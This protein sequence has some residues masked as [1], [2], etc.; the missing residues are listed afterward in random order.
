MADITLETLIEDMAIAGGPDFR[1]YKRN[2]LERSLRKRM[3]DL[4]L[5]SL[6][7]YADFFV[8]NRSEVNHLQQ[9]LLINVTAFFRDSLAWEALAR[10]ALP[11]LLDPL[12]PGDTFHAWCAGCATGEEAFSLA[13]LLAEYLGPELKHLNVTI[14]A[15]DIDEEALKVARK[16]E[17]PEDRFNAVSPRLQEQYFDFMGTSTLRVKSEIRRM[18]IFRRSNLAIDAPIAPVHL[19]IC[20]NLLIYFDRELQKKVIGQFSDALAN[21]GVLFLGR[22]ESPPPAYQHFQ[23]L[24]TKWRIYQR[25]LGE[26]RAETGGQTT[27]S[28]ERPDPELDPLRCV[29]RSIV[30]ALPQAVLFLDAT[31]TIGT[32]NEAARRLWQLSGSLEGTHITSTILTEQSRELCEYFQRSH[33]SGEE[34]LELELRSRAE[35]KERRV[36]V[37]LQNLLDAQKKRVGTLIYAED[38]SH[39]EELRTAV[40]DLESTGEELRSSK[41]ALRITNE[42]LQATNEELEN[43]NSALQSMN[44]ELETTNEELHSLN[45]ELEAANDELEMR[46]RELD[47]TNR[48]YAETLE[49]MPSPVVL[50]NEHSKIALWNS[51][52]ES[53]FALESRHAVG[54]HVQD[55]PLAADW[56][57]VIAQKVKAVLLE[58]HSVTIQSRALSVASLKGEVE[59]RFTPVTSSC[60]R[61]VLVIVNPIQ[62]KRSRRVAKRRDAAGQTSRKTGH[63]PK[64]TPGV[65]KRSAPRKKQPSR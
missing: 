55:L 45:E 33:R 51:A 29:L 56:R 50:V 24:N 62:G 32:V 41:E 57:N 11:R 37:R 28:M 52:A 59:I 20:R 22:A 49:H 27:T 48:R 65:K 26:V 42:E 21:G 10:Q 2:S 25:R 17:Y 5:D 12:R 35:G 53:F 1:G 39:R 54:C 64:L 40:R 14:H 7:G 63:T 4:K 31:D 8:H 19:L 6:R 30:S 43:T 36:L 46:T 34:P 18:V 38:V 15:T 47:E 13:I 60:P 58:Q 61:A 9:T 3:N 23:P 44:E 16:A